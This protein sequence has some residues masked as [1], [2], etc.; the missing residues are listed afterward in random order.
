MARPANGTP[1]G[2]HETEHHDDRLR[3]LGR[4]GRALL[5][6]SGVLVYWILLAAPWSDV[7]KGQAVLV[8]LALAALGVVIESL[9]RPNQE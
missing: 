5:L 7:A 3:R 2:F 1:S 4:V 9:K 6:V 8:T